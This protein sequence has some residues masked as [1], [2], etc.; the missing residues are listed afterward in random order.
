MRVSPQA[1]NRSGDGWLGGVSLGVPQF[2][3]GGR[4]G[5]GDDM[6]DAELRKK[7]SLVRNG[8][9][10]ITVILGAKQA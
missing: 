2:I 10:L 6:S 1:L 8:M 9:E 4:S 7:F 5:L 3:E